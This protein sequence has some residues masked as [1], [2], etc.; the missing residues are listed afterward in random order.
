LTFDGGVKIS[1]TCD[2]LPKQWVKINDSINP[3]DILIPIPPQPKNTIGDNIFAGL[4]FSSQGVAGVYPAFLTKKLYGGDV[5][6]VSSNGFLRYD[7]VSSEYQIASK[8]KFD[9][10]TNKGNYLSLNTKTCNVVGEGKLSLGSNLG[11]VNMDFYGRVDNKKSDL[12]TT[13]TS[14]AILD[15]FFNEKALEMVA[16][17]I[18]ASEYEKIS[19]RISSYFCF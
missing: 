10:I 7:E 8:E 12:S 11:R 18:L 19:K 2:T 9:G 1:H 14:N 6:L 15:F 16:N 17:D 5:E 13:I 4:Y 3:D